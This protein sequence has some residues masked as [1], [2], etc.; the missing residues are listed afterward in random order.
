VSQD[1]FL[2]MFFEEARELL[3][4]LEAGLVDLEAKC[5]DRAHLDR[6]FRAAHTLKGAAGMVGLRPIADFTHGVEAVLDHIRSG[7]LKVRPDVIT[8]LL[9]ARDHLERAV[10]GAVGGGTVEPEPA[11]AAFLADLAANPEAAP[12]MKGSASTSVDATAATPAPVLEGRTSPDPDAKRHRIT[13]EPG[14]NQFREGVHPEGFLDELREL[15]TLEVEAD[16]SRVPDL[17]SID[18]D[19]CYL[20]WTAHLTTT[21]PTKRIEEVFFLMGDSGRFT[22]ETEGTDTT[23]PAPIVPPAPLPAP[24][25]APPP[26][27]ASAPASA[28][29]AASAAETKAKVVKPTAKLRVEAEQLDELLGLAGELAILTDSLQGLREVPESTP[30][31][32]TLEALERLGRRLR[33]TTLELRMVPIE[34]LFNRFPRLVRDLA[35]RIGKPIQLRIEGEDTRLDRTIIERLSEPMVHMIRN[36]IDHGLEMPDDRLKAGKPATGRLT[37]GAGYEGD[38]VAIRI[39]DDG[40]GLDRA[41][42]ARKGVGLGLL[43]PEI[44]PDDP[45]VGNLIFEA[46]FSTKD[47][48]GELSGR[49]VG[50][51]VVRETIRSL[52]GSVTVR[53]LEGQGTTFLIHLPL[54]LALIDGLLIEVAGARYVVPMTQVDECVALSAADAAWSLHR[55]AVVVRGELIPLVPLRRAFGLPLAELPRQELLLTQ[56]GEQKV[57]VAVDRLLGRVQTVIQP[58]DERMADVH[59]FSGATIL[60]DGS[61]C[62]ILDLASVVSQAGRAEP[63]VAVVS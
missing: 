27:G 25:E 20:A 57:G 47:K 9:S 60:G 1:L 22:I 32:G 8:A 51:D 18:P 19:A 45:R 26:S 63:A 7:R 23:S 44:A 16:A 54:T 36:A 34:E 43:P 38:R 58:L 21:A 15:G 30:W 61:I 29:A 31:A 11:L 52:R 12:A 55:R 13:I 46:G 4:A 2:S 17:D 10:E 28:P 48:A 56:H 59:Q 3:Q 62:L 49:G 39:R 40:K 42:I 33:D 53:S 14:L 50:L 24:T 6:T 35:E 5:D 41:R 37:I